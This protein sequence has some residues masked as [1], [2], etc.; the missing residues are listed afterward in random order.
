[1]KF[2]HIGKDSFD[3]II[4]A[5]LNRINKIA[6]HTLRLISNNVRIYKIRP[7]NSSKLV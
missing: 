1:M 7:F 4:D 2:V 6:L 5:W 3:L